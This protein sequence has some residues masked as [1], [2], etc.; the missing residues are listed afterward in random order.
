MLSVFL[1]FF[2]EVIDMKKFKL[3]SLLLIAT[4]AVSTLT[5]CSTGNANADTKQSNGDVDIVIGTANGSLCLAPYT[6]PSI[7]DILKKNSRQQV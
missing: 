5:A 7:T 4:L 1:I 2:Y 6:S 3:T